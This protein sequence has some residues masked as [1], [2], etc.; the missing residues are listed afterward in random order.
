MAIVTFGE[1]KYGQE[2]GCVNLCCNTTDLKATWPTTVKAGSTMTV[3]NESTE[4]V[5]HCELF[6]G[7]V[8]ARI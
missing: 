5:D 4:V 1:Y 6:S 8:W 7:A 2:E 3:V